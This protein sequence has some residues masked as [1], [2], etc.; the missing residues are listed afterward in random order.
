MEPAT[1]EKP[2]ARPPSGDSDI[3]RYI[4]EKSHEGICVCQDGRVV[5]AN[6][7]FRGMTGYPEEELYAQPLLAIVDPR[8]HAHVLEQFTKRMMGGNDSSRYAFRGVTKGGEVRWLLMSAIRILWQGRPAALDFVADITELKEAQEREYLGRL[9]NRSLVA[10][11]LESLGILAGGVAHDFNN[12][13][14][15]IIGFGALAK[16]EAAGGQDPSE[17]IEEVLAACERAKG[18]IGQILAFASRLPS[19]PKPLRLKPVVEEAV[20]F[21]RTT[22]PDSI[23]VICRC[24]ADPVVLADQGNLHQIVM[25]LCTNA[26]FALGENGGELAVDLALN[27]TPGEEGEKVWAALSVRDGG[28]GMEP[29][30]KERIFEPFYST[31]QGSGGTGLGL[32]VV[33][34]IVSALGGRIEC[35]SE[36]GDGTVFR[37]HLPVTRREPVAEGSGARTGNRGA[38]GSERILHVEDEPSLTRLFHK[39]LSRLGYRV[40]S[41]NSAA[42][43]LEIFSEA[44]NVF[45]IVLVDVSMPHMGGEELTRKIKA[46]R[47]ELPVVAYSGNSHHFT[48]ERIENAGWEE[49]LN[50]PVAPADFAA[51][52]REIMDREK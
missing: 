3:Y 40:T 32:S 18:L 2:A 52:V 39:A 47:R 28:C 31:R 25:N 22:A 29:A 38:V 27:E 33:H 21:I 24:E 26:V 44:P 4:F 19:D 46:L 11:R 15:V 50:K 9:H 42:H 12:L 14:N 34:G 36:P 6:P 43:A 37:V 17:S 23:T 7:A 10:Q 8:D 45:D 16:T 20:K 49:L 1:P 48:A 35:D 30:V 41:S 51:K 5:F 13:L